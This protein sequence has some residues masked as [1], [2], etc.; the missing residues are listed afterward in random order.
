MKT[1]ICTLLLLSILLLACNKEQSENN[2]EKEIQASVQVQT[3][4]LTDNTI[5][6]TLNVYGQVLPLPNAL[7][8]LSV[9]FASRIIK[10]Y[11]AQG[12]SV[13]QGEALLSV[14]PDETMQLALSQ[15]QEELSAAKQDLALVQGRLALKLATQHELLTAQTRV[16]QAEAMLRD[17]TA[18]GLTHQHILTA[19]TAGII[20]ALHV[21][22]GQ[23]LASAMPLLEW[24]PQQQISVTLGVEPENIEQLQLNQSVTLKPINR[25]SSSQTGHITLINAQVDPLS[26]LLNIIVKPD[27]PAQLLL[28]EAVQAEI[29][30]A[31]KT[32]LVAPRAAVLPDEN[33]YKV[34]TVVDNKAV[35]HKVEL[36]LQNES[37]VELI[38]P[39]LKANDELVILGNYELQD[40][41]SV[42]TLHCNVCTTGT[43]P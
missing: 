35:K 7:Q 5:S 17:L 34:F 10:V 15:A 16:V 1:K 30:L 27:K 24:L 42:E 18:R 31:T 22:Q 33:A 3:Q 40:G 12:Q 23:R 19:P 21:G 39:T 13:K 4:T 29:T 41:M 32:T 25:A 8:T 20:T 14:Q 26:H 36:G 9:A 2:S 28:N 43:Q 37:Q 38:A 6:Q 11:V